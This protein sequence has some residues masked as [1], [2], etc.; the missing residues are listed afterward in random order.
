MKAITRQENRNERRRLRK[1]LAA[2]RKEFP[3][4]ACALEH[5]DPLQL[6]VATILSAQ[7]TDARVNMVTPALFARY[8]TADDFAKADRGE[9]ESMIRSTGF[10]AN[11]TKNI[12]GCCSAIM[13]RFHGR[14]PRT[15]E[16][17]VSLPG[18]GRKTANVVLGN[19]FRVPGFAVDTHVIRLSNLLGFTTSRD[20]GV[21][22]LDMTAL[23][24]PKEWTDASHL[25]I[26]H[27]RKTCIARRPRCAACG[28]ER[29]CP[30]STLRDAGSAAG[31]GGKT[32][33]RG[34][35]KAG[36]PLHVPARDNK[37]SKR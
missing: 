4:P 27:G 30:S 1:I 28:I 17:L 23:M 21:I 29:H 9:L 16:D 8:R 35:G 19:A 25:L 12:I 32:K 11:K 20:P 37:L 26:L 15:M 31:A 3:E 6:L 22:E 14:V 10:Y 7:C 24:P 33:R 36:A 34:A 2:L 5:R 18:V 13:E